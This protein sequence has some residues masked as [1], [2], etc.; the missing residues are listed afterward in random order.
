[1]SDEKL[2]KI[3]IERLHD[4]KQHPFHV[5]DDKEMA[6]LKESI[7]VLGILNPLI[8]RPTMD[9]VYEIIA[10]H[11]RK[12]ADEQ[13]GYQKLPVIIRVMNDDEAR[14]LQRREETA[15]NRFKDISR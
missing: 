14:L 13:L 15:R 8:V 2:I 6:L 7:K 11:R 12:Y 3:E 10:G 1:M 5:N 9:G 4:L